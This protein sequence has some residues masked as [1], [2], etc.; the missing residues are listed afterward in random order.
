MS[1]FAVLDAAWCGVADVGRQGGVAKPDG[2]L[3]NNDFVAF[4]DLFFAGDVRADLG[5]QG[6]LPG[7]DGLFDNNDFIEFIGAF[8]DGCAG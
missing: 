4:I 2:A 8:F 7:R 6:G 5:V 3:D 1:N